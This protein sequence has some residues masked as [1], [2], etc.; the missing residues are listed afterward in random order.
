MSIALIHYERFVNTRLIELSCCAALPKTS[1]TMTAKKHDGKT[2]DVKDAMSPSRRTD[3]VKQS[4]WSPG[5][6][7]HLVSLMLDMTRR[8]AALHDAVAD[9]RQENR[10]G[11]RQLRRHMLKLGSSQNSA[12]RPANLDSS[13]PRSFVQSGILL[14]CHYHK[15][16]Y[17]DTIIGDRV[18]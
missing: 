16:K 7:G 9:M 14:Y 6:N 18:K 5:E 17:A 12:N 4:P 10:L 3:G 8:V 15:L 11:Y 1:S 2:L 13:R